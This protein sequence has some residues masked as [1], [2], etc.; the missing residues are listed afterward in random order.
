MVIK[1]LIQYSRNTGF[2]IKKDINYFDQIVEDVLSEINFLYDPKKVRIVKKYSKKEKIHTDALRLKIILQNLIS[3][4]IKYRKI[5]VEQSNVMINFSAD[6]D[7]YQIQIKDDG[8]GIDPQLQEKIFTMFYRGTEQSDGSGLG[9]YIVKETLN[10]LNGKIWV[11]SELN[12]YT[13]VGISI[14]KQSK[15]QDEIAD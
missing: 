6:K 15:N 3:N 10:K 2:K 1:G 7:E 5:D 11:E 14:P 13:L 8:I 4:A 9:L 12:S